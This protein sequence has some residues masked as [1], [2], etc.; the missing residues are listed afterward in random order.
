MVRPFEIWSMRTGVLKALHIFRLLVRMSFSASGEE[1]DGL[2]ED[3]VTHA[4]EK[5]YRNGDN[6][7][8][9]QKRVIR[10]KAAKLVLEDGILWQFSLKITLF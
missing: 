1:V 6:L 2:F 10:K 4:R 7:T 3:A 8:A 5:V 9:N